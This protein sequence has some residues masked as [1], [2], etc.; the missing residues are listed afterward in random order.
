MSLAENLYF[1]DILKKYAL[2]TGPSSPAVRQARTVVP[3]LR[4]WAGSYLAGMR[5]TG[6]YAKGTRVRGATDIDIFISL[7]QRRPGSLREIFNSLLSYLRESGWK[8]T[9]GNVAVK[10]S[11]GGLRLDVVPG[12]RQHP[13][14]G[15]HSLYRRRGDAWIQTNPAAHVRYVRNLRRINEIRLAKI[16]RNVHGLDFP[17]FCLELAVIEALRGRSLSRL[18]ANFGAVLDYL[19]T[20]FP[21][22]RLV[23]PANS[24]NVV[25]DEMTA[26][27]TRSIAV[28]AREGTAASVWE[29]V[30][31]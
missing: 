7:S 9:A 25:S 11:S 6:S 22:A 20:S 8:V 5:W 17:S 14:G 30:I 31:W 13:Q 23:D 26:S 12:R 21:Q 3:T 19:A 28:R 18:P 10:V 29:Q 15:D 24:N 16:W 4:N 2:P 27:E 1:R